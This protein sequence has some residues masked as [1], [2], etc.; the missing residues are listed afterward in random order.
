MNAVVVYGLTTWAACTQQKHNNTSVCVCVWC[1]GGGVSGVM[2]GNGI[3]SR[4][5][6]MDTFVHWIFANWRSKVSISTDI[7]SMEYV[8]M[9]ILRTD[10]CQMY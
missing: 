1:G 5:W 7:L 6:K 3:F 9:A 8:T 4:M 10:Y 2:E